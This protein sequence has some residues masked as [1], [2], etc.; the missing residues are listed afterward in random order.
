MA[1]DL[2]AKRRSRKRR[3]KSG[4]R[5]GTTGGTPAPQAWTPDS[6]SPRWRRLLGLIPGYDPI[7]T[8]AQPGTSEYAY[9]F[10]EAEADLRVAFFAECLTH[11]EGELAGQ[12]FALRDWQQA[13]VG[14]LFGWK[15]VGRS[16]GRKVGTDGASAFRPSDPRRYREVLLYVPRGNGK[17]P[18]AAGVA[19][20]CF[21]QD[22]EPG[23]QI[24]CLANDNKQADAVFR[25]ICEQIVNEPELAARCRVFRGYRSIE[26]TG[27]GQLGF[28][29]VISGKPEGKHGLNPH[30]SLVDELHELSSR[31]LLEAITSAYVKKG[32]RQPLLVFMTTADFDR[33]SLCNEKYDYACQVRDGKLHDPR[34]LP[35]IYAADAEDDWTSEDVWARVNP[36]LDVSVSREALRAKCERA[37]AIPSEENTFKRLHLNIRTAQDKRWLLMHEWDACEHKPADVAGVLTKLRCYGGLDLAS[38][39]DLAAFG[40]CGAEPNG[41]RHYVRVW[42]WLPSAKLQGDDS[43]TRMLAEWAKAGLIEA[44]PGDVIDYRF[45]RR[46]INEIAKSHELVEIAYD[47]WNAEHLVQELVE[48]DGLSAKKFAQTAANFNAPCRRLEELLLARHWV[49]DGNA[50]LRWNA[51]NASIVEDSHGNIRPDKRRSKNKIDGLIAA[52][53]ALGMV[54]VNRRQKRESVYSK[55]GALVI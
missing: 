7:A 53:M 20:S 41:E 26:L 46:R 22:D 39:R 19:N 10:D 2:D 27:S 16:E 49:H 54:M 42:T 5:P 9:W 28:I 51:A 8:A 17:S 32:R 6:I 1:R 48:E 3:S 25:P 31:H 13:V 44:T 18:L 11:I 37:R 40:L 4:R 24:Y 52:L 15:E 55:R 47:P 38:T 14:C 21:F 12:P 43:H 23:S 33:E 50:V 30:L 45:I 29:R 34:F 36:N 35:V